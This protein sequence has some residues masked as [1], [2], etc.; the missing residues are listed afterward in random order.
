MPCADNDGNEADAPWLSTLASR[1]TLRKQNIVYSFP[2]SKVRAN[3]F[4]AH[5][6]FVSE[7]R[8]GG[9]ESS[10]LVRLLPV[11]TK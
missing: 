11:Q 10:D 9:D 2:V 4:T 3:R 6:P 7:G 8:E 1:V 5:A